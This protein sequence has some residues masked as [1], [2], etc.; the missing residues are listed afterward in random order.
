MNED[1]SPKV[2]PLLKQHCLESSCAWYVQHCRR[3]AMLVMGEA[4]EIATTTAIMLYFLYV[5][6]SSI[7]SL[8]RISTSDTPSPPLISLNP[9]LNVISA[10][11]LH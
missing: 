2:C 10:K 11:T 3:C 5:Y 9:I 8:R 7:I 6:K 1:K 4:G